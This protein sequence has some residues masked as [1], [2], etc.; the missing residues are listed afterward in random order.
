MRKARLISVL[1]AEG[2]LADHLASVW[3]AQ[4]SD[5][6]VKLLQAHARRMLG[7]DIRRLLLFAQT[8]AA[9]QVRAGEA[10]NRRDAAA[11]ALRRLRRSQTSGVDEMQ[12]DRLLELDVNGPAL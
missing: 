1:Q 9:H 3:N 10:A 6:L 8:I 12:D 4:R 7:D 2:R 11:K 5:S